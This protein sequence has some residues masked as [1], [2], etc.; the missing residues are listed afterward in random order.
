ME[1]VSDEKGRMEPVA[2]KGLDGGEAEGHGRGEKGR[3]LTLCQID[4]G[5]IVI[6]HDFVPVVPPPGT[7]PP[8]CPDNGGRASGNRVAPGPCPL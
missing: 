8:S 1:A 5:H 4:L 7:V 2:D 6:L 3:S